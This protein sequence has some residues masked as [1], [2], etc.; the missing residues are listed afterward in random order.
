MIRATLIAV[1]LASATLV[2]CASGRDT[3]SSYAAGSTWGT[4]QLIDA[5]R[6][7]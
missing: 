7:V 4:Q 5:A 6:L 1:V 3:G 2:A